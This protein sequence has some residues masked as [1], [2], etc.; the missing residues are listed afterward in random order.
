MGNRMSTASL[1]HVARCTDIPPNG[2]LGVQVDG[3][4][5][6]LVRGEDAADVRAFDGTCPHQ[7][8]LLGDGRI[9]GGQLVCSGHGWRFDCATGRHARNPEACLHRFDVLVVDGVAMVPADELDAFRRLRDDSAQA[10]R[11]FAS[12]PGPKRR[13]LVGNL[14][15]LSE[16]T[17]HLSLE[18]WADEYGPLY[19]IQLGPY[20]ILVVS[21]P[22]LVEEVFKRR[23]DTY[24]RLSSVAQIT[25]EL[26]AGG[27]FSAEGDEWR[28][29]RKVTT[30]A[31]THAHIK[32]FFPTMARIVARLQ[33][34]WERA[35]DEGRD[36]DLLE[37]LACFTIDVTSAFAFGQDLNTIEGHEGTLQAHIGEIPKAMSRR[38]TAW[39]PYWRVVPLHAD[40]VLNRAVADMRV[41]LQ[42]LIG[43]TRRRLAEDPG[44]AERPT[45][46]LE[47]LLAQQA[48]VEGSFSDEDVAGNAMTLLLAGEET[49][50]RALAWLIYFMCERD[51]LMPALRAESDA[52]LG[53]RT[54]L[55]AFADHA[56]LVRIEAAAHEAMRL[57]PAAPV[58]RFEALHD[59]VLGDVEVP[60]RTPVFVM[61]RHS[62]IREQAATGV[63]AFD[64]ERWIKADGSALDATAAKAFF[65][66]GAGPRFCP[67][68]FL[69]LLEIKAVVSMLCRNFDLERADH[70][71]VEEKL[72]FTMRPDN[73]AIRL[74]R[75]EQPLRAAGKAASGA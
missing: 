68:R 57:K 40:R 74:A 60:A 11:P 15:Q 22:A 44:L 13:P 41:T 72:V 24:R 14:F 36:I 66:F 38:C 45:N 43:E 26:G 8:A 75:R 23:P 52:V 30:Q 49:T 67:G 29:Q 27:V 20:H 47:G 53:E 21:D 73:L 12:L 62:T 56:R 39:V 54:V 6:V 7:G 55:D 69:A 25:R 61:T 32:H 10:T 42:R 65:P 51:D 5:L 50:A 3:I 46:Y 9:E 35:A 63:E 59:T 70:G 17:Q 1:V 28:R 48:A 18:D 4:H 19:R 2:L 71:P 16:D 33:A 58:M 64:I 31:L 37:D 34:R